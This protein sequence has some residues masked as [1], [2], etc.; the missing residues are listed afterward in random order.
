MVE[1]DPAHRD[2]V[3]LVLLEG[4]ILP[5]VLRGESAEPCRAQGLQAHRVQALDHLHLEQRVAGENQQPVLLDVVDLAAAVLPTDLGTGI[6]E[7]HPRQRQV[8]VQL[9]A[10]PAQAARGG[11]PRAVKM[12]DGRRPHL[13]PLALAQRLRQLQRRRAGLK[14]LAHQ[15]G[16]RR[17]NRR[18]PQQQARDPV[19]HLGLDAAAAVVL[20]IDVPGLADPS[21]DDVLAAVIELADHVLLAFAVELPGKPAGPRL[22]VGKGRAL[23]VAPVAAARLQHAAQRVPVTDRPQPLGLGIGST[24]QPTDHLILD[25]D[26][27]RRIVGREVRHRQ[28]VLAAIEAAA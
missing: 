6:V 20:E 25:R 4:E 12:K 9:L 27:A 11:H 24:Q 28:R 5:A 1:L 21:H 15:A 22:I 7:Q 10:L 8:D 26:E 2:V 18:R 14:L 19:G 16:H 3:V 13:Q 23:A 17:R